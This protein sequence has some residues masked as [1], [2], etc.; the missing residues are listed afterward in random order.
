M[1]LSVGVSRMTASGHG[2]PL[3]L[4]WHHDRYTSAADLP[5]RLSRQ[6]RAT[7]RHQLSATDFETGGWDIAS[8]T[9]ALDM[10]RS[11]ATTILSAFRLRALLLSAQ[12]HVAC[13][14]LLGSDY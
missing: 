9:A 5:R 4:C 13:R 11:P 14:A 7:T 3:R 2:L 1:S 8:A 12:A 6:S 10:L